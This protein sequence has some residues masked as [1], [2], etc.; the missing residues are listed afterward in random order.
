[1]RTLIA[2]PWVVSALGGASA[3]SGCGRGCAG[4][5]G[6]CAGGC[7]GCWADC[8][9]GGRP[10]VS[11]GCGPVW[12]WGC[13]GASPSA[14]RARRRP[15]GGTSCGWPPFVSWLQLDCW[16]SGVRAAGSAGRPDAAG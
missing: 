4:A 15:V 6:H 12:A 11:A 3:G 9:A 1:M 5:S 14:R 7:A 13:S 16:S 2:R 8:W 10:L